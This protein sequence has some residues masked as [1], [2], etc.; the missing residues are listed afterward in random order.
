MWRTCALV[1]RRDLRF[2]PPGALTD[3]SA[4]GLASIRKI[5]GGAR[6]HLVRSG[7]LLFEHGC[8]QASAAQ[9]HSLESRVR[10]PLI[11]ERTSPAFPEFPVAARIKFTQFNESG[12]HGHPRHHPRYRH[13]E[14]GGAVRRKARRNFPCAAFRPPPQILKAC[15]VDKPHRGRAANE[16][17]IR[18]GIREYANWPTIPQLY[19][20]GEF[21]GGADIMRRC[22]QSGELQTLLA[23][24]K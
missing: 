1:A 6:K 3:Q 17:D 7:W 18:Q 14:Q 8:D 11:C 21:V 5:A 2:E 16:R 13:P 10:R 15:G 24:T 20:N 4:D 12:N 22:I 23:S 9:R 19:V